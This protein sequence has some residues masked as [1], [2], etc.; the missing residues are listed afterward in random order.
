MNEKKEMMLSRQDVRENSLIKNV[1]LWMTLGL[2]LTAAVS[3]LVSMSPSLLKV[4]TQNIGGSLLLVCAQF[5]LVIF[6]SSR[7]EKMQAQSA[8]IAFCAYAVVTGISLSVLFL[9]YTG[10][11]LAQAFISTAL[12]FG[13]MS[14]YAMVTKRNLSG[15]GN[16]LIMGLWGLIIASLIGLFFHST[17]FELVISFIGIA[18]FLGLAAYDTQRVK[19][20]N[21]QYGSEMTSDEFTKLGIIGALNLYLDFLNIF[22]YVVRILGLS[23]R[24]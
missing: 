17:M 12:M 10:S 2:A 19:A 7:I 8:I 4:F 23:R 20:I 1:Y 22:L 6:L 18:L 16:Y 11:V 21:D 3:Y 24:D 9:V 15:W 5:G 14:V 13:G